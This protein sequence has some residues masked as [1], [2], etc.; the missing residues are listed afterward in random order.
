MFSDLQCLPTLVISES[1]VIDEGIEILQLLEGCSDSLSMSNGVC[2]SLLQFGN[3]VCYWKR[4][5]N[6]L[7]SDSVIG[8]HIYTES[9]AGLE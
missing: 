5:W 6:E 2:L 3:E 8:S 1:E 4:L 9:E 7:P